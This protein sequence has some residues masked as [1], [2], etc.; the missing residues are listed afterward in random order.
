VG[1]HL[2]SQG[3]RTALRN[4]KVWV[5]ELQLPEPF[6]EEGKVMESFIHSKK[7]ALKHNLGKML[8]SSGRE[9]FD[10]VSSGY[11]RQDVQ[12]DPKTF[13]Y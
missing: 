10:L 12:I 1:H 6:S 7:I 4:A 8:N 2:A 13:P 5:F 3:G 11:R 9:A